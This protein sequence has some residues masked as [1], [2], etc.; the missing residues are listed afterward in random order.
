MPTL[1]KT[2]LVVLLLVVCALSFAVSGQTNCPHLQSG[3]VNFSTLSGWNVQGSDIV[4]S[5]QNVLVDQTSSA[6]LRSIVVESGSSLIFNNVVLNLNVEFIKVK[7]GGSFIMGSATCP[8]TN[9]IIVT[10]YGNRTTE[11]IIGSDPAD[12]TTTGYKGLVTMT[13]SS[14]AC[15]GEVYGPTWTDL[16]VTAKKGTSTITVRQNT[17]WRVGDKLVIATTDYS[18]LYHWSDIVPQSLEWKKGF[19]F[20]DQNEERTITQ[21]VNSRTFI[22]NSPLNYTHFG[23]GDQRAEV[24]VLNR[25]IVFQGDASSDTSQF[26]GHIM[27]RPGPRAEIKGIE[28]TR[29]GLAG[30]MGRYPIHF[31]VWGEKAFENVGNYF[32]N[33]SSI[34]HTYQRCIVVHDT[35]GL[36]I[37]G[38]IC[39]SNKGHQFFLEDGVEMGNQFLYNLGIKPIPVANED[40]YQLLRSDSEVASLWITNANN[41]FIGNHLVGGKHPIWFTQPKDATGKFGIT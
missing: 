13:G 33:D 25:N 41:S 15:Y 12:A 2:T 24:G 23:E 10:F 32:V 36:T 3:L 29:M 28:L 40:S 11:N 22:L 31:H 26:G 17:S 35:N 5:G 39:F 8:I 27:L 34:H 38:N 6:V 1:A 9:K 30:I 7:S 21:V 19:G 16:D 14:I 37:S 20:K 18:D 4:I